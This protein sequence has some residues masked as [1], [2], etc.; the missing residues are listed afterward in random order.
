MNVPIRIL[1]IATSIFW[2][3]L[4][5]FIATA[6]YSIGDLSFSFGEPQFTVAPNRTLLLSLPLHINNSG[7]STLN[8]FN[9][10]T[11]LSTA[12]GSELSRAS[13]FVPTIPQRQNVTIFHNASLSIGSLLEKEEKY[14]FVDSNLTISVAAELNFAELIPTQL[15]TNITYLWGAPLCNFA[16]G[17][18]SYDLS[19]STQSR[20]TVP[21]KFENHASFD[22][23]GNI[24]VQLYDSGNSLLGESQTALNIPSKSPCNAKFEFQVPLTGLSSIAARSGHLSVFFFTQLFDYGPLVIPYG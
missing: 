17:Q 18:P 10:T 19:S 24:K 13:S 7:Y 4:I 3:V 22:L 11:M 14:L 9:I 1:G 5:A 20:I 8:A 16:L 12:D 6:A 23:T 21:L 2:I 15:S